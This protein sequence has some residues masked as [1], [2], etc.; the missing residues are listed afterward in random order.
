MLANTSVERF[1]QNLST[2]YESIDE[3]DS[4]WEAFLAGWYATFGDTPT[5]VA[6]VVATL[7]KSETSS[8]KEAV[9][10]DLLDALAGKGRTTPERKLGW[11]LRKHDG[12][13]FGAYV[14]GRDGK[15]HQAIR[16]VVRRGESGSQGSLFGAEASPDEQNG[17]SQGSPGSHSGAEA[18]PG[19]P[20]TTPDNGQRPADS[21]GS[22]VWCCFWCKATHRFPRDGH[23][24]CSGCHHT[25]PMEPREPGAEG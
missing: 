18:P 9:H 6:D 19:A 1:L 13:I 12:A 11:L 10:P 2:L 21:P 7:K 4:A 20:Y 22:P 16:W 14:L 5:T 15:E 24:V 23:W 8:V 17:G 3:G 25:T